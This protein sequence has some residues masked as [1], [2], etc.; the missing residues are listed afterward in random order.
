MFSGYAPL[1]LHPAIHLGAYGRD[2][3]PDDRK[4]GIEAA[5]ALADL[6]GC[7]SD[8]RLWVILHDDGS[9]SEGVAAESDAFRCALDPIHVDVDK[10][11]ESRTR[12]GWKTRMMEAGFNE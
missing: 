4:A 9:M 8:G 12:D 11:V 6:V 7:H 10:W 1:V 2:E 5:C 3:D